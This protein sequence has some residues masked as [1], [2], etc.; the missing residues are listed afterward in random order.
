MYLPAKG[1]MTKEWQEEG[2][3]CVARGKVRGGLK[4][5]NVRTPG[6]L[7]RLQLIRGRLELLRIRNNL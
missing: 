6:G 2:K 3:S 7:E 4:G 1:R 5:L